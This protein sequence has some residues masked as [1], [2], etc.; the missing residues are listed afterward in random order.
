MVAAFVL[1]FLAGLGFGFSLEGRGKFIPLIF[2]I[3]LSIGAFIQWGLDGAIFVRLI[4]ALI[5]TVIGIVLGTMLAARG[6]GE[7]AD[8]R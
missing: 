4:V 3:I 6:S 1:F 2:P 8:A 5:I 7:A